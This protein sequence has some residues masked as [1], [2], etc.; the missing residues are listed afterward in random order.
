MV[1]RLLS[2]SH[3]SLQN[4]GLGRLVSADHIFKSITLASITHFFM[5]PIV[6]WHENTTPLGVFLHDSF[7]AAYFLV[8]MTQ[9]YSSI[10][11]FLKSL[12]HIDI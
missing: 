8:G 12:E 11:L 1:L 7:V 4:E 3:R 5:L 6:V 10:V 9:I 2:L